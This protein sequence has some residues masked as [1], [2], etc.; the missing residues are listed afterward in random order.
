MARYTGAVCRLC[1]RE[2]KK[3]FLKG[4]RCY[5]DKCAVTRRATV[6]GQHGKARARKSSEYGIQLRAKQQA[7]RYAVRL[8][9]PA[10]YGDLIVEHPWLGAGTPQATERHILLAVRLMRATVAL[11]AVV[12]SLV[13]WGVMGG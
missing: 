8:G 4:E 12:L 5:T 11:T 10:V 2:N 3:L 13:S 6:P 1:R 9:G 7:R